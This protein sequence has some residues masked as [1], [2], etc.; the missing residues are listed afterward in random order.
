M[1]TTEMLH[2][3]L[4]ETE[5]HMNTTYIRVATV[6]LEL[7]PGVE[8]IKGRKSNRTLNRSLIDYSPTD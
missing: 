6:P 2:L 8:T 4:G 1:A 3:C 5:V 7:R